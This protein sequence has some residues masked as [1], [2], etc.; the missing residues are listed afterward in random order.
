MPRPPSHP[1]VVRTARKILG[2]SQK[3]LA[4]RVGIATVTLQKF[5]NGDSSISQ[6]VAERIA[7][8]LEVDVW[9]IIENRDPLHPRTWAQGKVVIDPGDKLGKTLWDLI[10]VPLTKEAFVDRVFTEKDI[11][12]DIHRAV[13]GLRLL[14]NDALKKKSYSWVRSAIFYRLRQIKMEF[15]LK[16]LPPKRGRPQNSVKSAKKPKRRSP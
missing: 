13:N 5:E 12:A 15:D 16:Q 11:E 1:H 4:A 7:S 6:E 8:E 9:D 10:K 3:D 2:I 14:L